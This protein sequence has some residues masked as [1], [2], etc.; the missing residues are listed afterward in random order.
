MRRLVIMVLLAFPASASAQVEAPAKGALTITPKAFATGDRVVV[1]GDGVV[2]LGGRRVRVRGVRTWRPRVA[3]GVYVAK[4][5]AGRRTIARFS[6]TVTGAAPVAATSAGVFPIRGTWTFG[7]GVGAA[8]TGR[9]HQGQDILAA[10]GTPLVSPV[11]GS[12]FFRKVQDSG[13]GDYLVIRD[14][15]GADYVFMHLVA[16]SE[17]VQRGDTVSAGQPIAQV[18]STGNA[19]GSLL[20][21]EIW[22]GGWYAPGSSPV[23]PLPQLRAWAAAG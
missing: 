8:R 20:H 13:A 16:G 12:V 19:T 2:H 21:F 17:L 23:D 7:E 15:A 18:G 6:V 22:P 14:R 5:R 4:L 10:E 11:D 1:S 3:P 9:S